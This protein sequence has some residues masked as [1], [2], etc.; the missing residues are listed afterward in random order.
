MQA[1]RRDR[2]VPEEQRLGH[3][4]HPVHDPTIWIEDDRV[5]QVGVV[6]E[7]HVLNHGADCGLVPVVEPVRG[8][9]LDEILQGNGLLGQGVRERDKP[10]YVPRV[11]PA[12]ARPEVIL[13][14]HGSNAS[15][16]DAS[17]WVLG[18]QADLHYGH[19]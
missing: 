12:A 13:L 10:V 14:T 1:L 2:R 7:S 4:V 3:P 9:D 15:G 6:N 19:P 16:G 18:V 11:Q 5:G 17:L 8:L